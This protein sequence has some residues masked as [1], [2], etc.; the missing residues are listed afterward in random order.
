MRVGAIFPQ[1]DGALDPR[2]MVA[3]IAGVDELGFDYVLVYEHILG[4]DDPSRVDSPYMTADT[5]FHEPLTLIAYLAAVAPRLGFAT[6]VLV[7]PL[8]QTALVAKQAAAVDILSG[9]GFRLGVGVGGNPLEFEGL[10]QDFTRRGRRCD[11]QIALLRRLWTEPI[12]EFSGEFDRID[13]A[14]INPRPVQQPIPV[15]VGGDSAAAMRRTALLGDGWMP[16]G[17]P[18][19]EFAARVS[20]LHDLATAT[21]RDPGEIGVEGRLSLSM[22]PPGQRAQEFERWRTMPGVTHLGIDTHRLGMRG[23]ERHLNALAGF[24]E[25]VGGLR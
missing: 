2:A 3:W 17:R 7:L 22:V 15:W 24:V 13:R 18:G 6:G 11:E 19:D 12:V 1:M 21:G 16:H 10:G 14:G 5:P 9:G 8:R 4:V 23:G 20:A 25:E